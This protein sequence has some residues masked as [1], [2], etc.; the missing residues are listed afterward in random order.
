MFAAYLLFIINRLAALKPAQPPYGTI[1]DSE[2]K[3]P[4]TQAHVRIFESRF[5][6][7]LETQAT[8]PK[9]R[10]AFIVHPGAYRILISKKGYKTVMLNFPKIGQ[11]G[12]LLARD[13]Q[14]KRM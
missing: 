9:G 6:K 11:E 4:L 13:V 2:T 14:M 8:S 10:Y 3:R 12:F 7:L 5:N 1:M